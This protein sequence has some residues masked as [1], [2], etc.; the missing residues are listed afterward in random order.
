MRD[1]GGPAFPRP[2]SEYTEHGT[3]PDGNTAIDEQDGMSLRDYFAAAALTGLLAANE[4]RDMDVTAKYAYRYA[5]FML[6]AQK[7]VPY[8]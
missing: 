5:D 4:D 3:L 1:D 2:A 6:Q 8:A 7:E